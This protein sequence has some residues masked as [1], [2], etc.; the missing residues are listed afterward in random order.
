[1]SSPAMEAMRNE[2]WASLTSSIENGRCMLMLGPDAF[3]AT[4]DGE[5]LP[6]AVGLARFVREKL[7]PAHAD[8]DPNRPWS[9]A[10]RA[11]AVE[12]SNT[13]LSWAEQFYEKTDTVSEPLQN[14][15]S[16]PFRYVVNTSPGFA[17][18][19][20]FKSVKP[21]TLSY[22]YNRAE[23][24]PVHLPDASRARADPLRPVRVIS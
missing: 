10:Q 3:R 7:G 16:L 21:D 19:L 6:V 4:I 14:F 9:V 5:D 18:E 23:P 22:F 8:L 20:A 2:D 15:A 12:D 17:A 24:A 11:I 13:L 1:M